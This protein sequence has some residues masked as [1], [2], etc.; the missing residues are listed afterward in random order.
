MI[1][2]TLTIS[3]KKMRFS[4]CH[5]LKYYYHQRSSR[6]SYERYL[7]ALEYKRAD[8]LGKHGYNMYMLPALLHSLLIFLESTDYLVRAGCLYL[9]S[10]LLP[11]GDVRNR[12]TVETFQKVRRERP[13][14]MGKEK[15]PPK[16]SILIWK[17]GKKVGNT[18]RLLLL[19][20]KTLWGKKE[21]KT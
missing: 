20:T 8:N 21:K 13:K 6:S 4:Q 14:R 17:K 7:G 9:P 15:E 19:L 16:I 1:A 12:K 10:S 18:P 2:I 11:R 3:K 5:S